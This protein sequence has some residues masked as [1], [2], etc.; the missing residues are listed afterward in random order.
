MSDELYSFFVS[1]IV[2]VLLFTGVIIFTIKN[3]KC[4]YKNK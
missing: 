4:S 2:T 1:V 3:D